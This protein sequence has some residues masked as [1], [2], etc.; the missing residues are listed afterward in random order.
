MKNFYDWMENIGQ[1]APKVLWITGMG[2]KGLAPKML[3]A[4]GY[5]VKHI[6]TTTNRY[7]AYLGRIKRFPVVNSLFGN[8]ADRLGQTHLAANAQKH[9]AEKQQDFIPDVV[10]GSSQ[11][12]AVTMQ[13]ASQYPH[14][15]FVLVAPAWRIFG[16]DPSHLPLDTIILHGKRDIQVPP[17]DSEMLHKKFGFKV[18]F[19]NAGHTVPLQYIKQAIDMQLAH[20][21]PI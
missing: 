3:A 10:V 18:L 1:D 4:Q 16:A 12:G 17:I 9:D 20:R 21:S 14:A 13:V 2:S 15:K 8:T 5:D 7:A 19:N 6:G 11:G